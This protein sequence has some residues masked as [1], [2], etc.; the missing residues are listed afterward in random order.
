MYRPIILDCIEKLDSYFQLA[1]DTSAYWVG[2]NVL[3]AKCCSELFILN[4][5]APRTAWLS[6][7]RIHLTQFIQYLQYAFEQFCHSPILNN[8]VLLGEESLPSICFKI[9]KDV[10]QNL[11]NS[12]L[13]P[14]THM[15]NTIS[16]FTTITMRHLSSEITALI[17]QFLDTDLSTH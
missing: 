3:T 11:I 16:F 17:H 8:Y 2:L 1:C 10:N 5:M 7:L 12:H 4:L 14:N 9:C 6:T 15:G 13:T